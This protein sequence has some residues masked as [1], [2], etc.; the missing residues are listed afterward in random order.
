LFDSTDKF[1]GR[2]LS[3]FV[4]CAFFPHSIL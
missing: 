2:S 3:V 1:G 4:D